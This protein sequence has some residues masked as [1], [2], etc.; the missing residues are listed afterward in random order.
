VVPAG[1]LRGRTG[2]RALTAVESSKPQKLRALLAQDRLVR[3][4]GAHNG[5]SARLVELSGFDAVWASGFE[6]SA[7]YAVP[8]ASILTMSETLE[9]ARVMNEAVSIPVIADCDTGYGDTPNVRHMVHRYEA[10]GIAGVCIEDK[11][12]PKM[13]SFVTAG[14]E[15]IPAESFA[16][17]IDAAKRAQ[18]SPDFVVIARTET[19]IVGEGLEEALRRAA[20]YAEAGADAVLVHSRQATPAEIWD[21]MARWDQRTPVVVVPTTYLADA[22]ELWRRGVRVVIYANHGIRAAA[23]AMRET[24]EELCAT[25][26]TRS[27]EDRIATVDEVLELQG[28]PGL[29]EFSR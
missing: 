15:L 14:Q 20:C 22:P 21:F 3:V 2:G 19:F 5:L 23:R 9:A 7:S 25:G 18:R 1:R 27:V 28:M 4:V 16:A 6:L 24:F 8:D 12:F 26:G 29:V 13:N 10:A 17:K 11:C